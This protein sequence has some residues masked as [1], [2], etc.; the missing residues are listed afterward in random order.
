MA[1]EYPNRDWKHDVSLG[2]VNEAIGVMVRGHAFPL[3]NNI[4]NSQVYEGSETEVH[5]GAAELL[6]I[7]SNDAADDGA[8]VGIGARTILLTGLDSSGVAEASCEPVDGAENRP[9]KGV[10]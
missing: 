8:P 9:K 10:A 2:K 6:D 5:W 4:V 7:V 3:A 1:A